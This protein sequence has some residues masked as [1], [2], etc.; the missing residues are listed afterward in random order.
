MR[1]KDWI[2]LVVAILAGILLLAIRV[3][4][5]RTMV[6]DFSL[7]VYGGVIAVIFAAVGV[8]TALIFQK[9]KTREN[10]DPISWEQVVSTYELTSRESEVLK[11]LS[12]GMTNKEIA[13]ALF[14]SQNTVKTHLSNIYTKLDVQRRT[15][16]VQ[17]VRQLELN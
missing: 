9:K 17:K 12:S 3:V 8:A 10:P 1:R 4:E 7:Q 13:E 5:Y 15:Q 2:I 6:S 14:V 16:A 11:L